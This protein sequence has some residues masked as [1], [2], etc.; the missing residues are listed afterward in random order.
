M[1]AYNVCVTQARHIAKSRKTFWYSL[2]YT[3]GLAP[4][5]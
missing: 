3:A 2:L 1:T 4:S 5:C